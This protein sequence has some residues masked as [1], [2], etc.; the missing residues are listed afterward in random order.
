VTTDEDPGDVPCTCAPVRA[1][2]TVVG[3]NWY[4]SCPT[5]GIGTAWFD[6]HRRADGTTM[7][8]RYE[9]FRRQLFPTLPA[10][11]TAEDDLPRPR[12]RKRE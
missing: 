1:G 3:T 5:H 10:R 7:R 11:W 8:E 12:R 2:S 4:E 6:G 9:A